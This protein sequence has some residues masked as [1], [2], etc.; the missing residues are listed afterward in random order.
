MF[1]QVGGMHSIIFTIGAIIVGIFASHIYAH[2]LLSS[3]YLVSKIKPSTI[4]PKKRIEE[5]KDIP[6]HAI[7]KVS[8][9]SND[10][11]NVVKSKKLIVK[12]FNRILLYNFLITILI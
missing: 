10:D 2:S 7:S 4:A 3:F 6:L 11:K 1:G 9:M 5:S 8:E 12:L